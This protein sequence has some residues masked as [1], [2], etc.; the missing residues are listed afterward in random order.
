MPDFLSEE[1]PANM[2]V[3]MVAI[4]LSRTP[5]T[6]TLDPSMS[7]SP[8]SFH[9]MIKALVETEVRPVKIIK[10]CSNC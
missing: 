6:S 4:I 1:L 2:T 10:K 9:K 8:E 3:E 5:E 7:V